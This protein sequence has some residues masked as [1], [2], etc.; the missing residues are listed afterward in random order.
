MLRILSFVDAAGGLEL[1][2]PV[3]PPG[4]DWVRS[5]LYETVHIDQLGTINYP[6]GKKPHSAV[7]ECLLPAHHY[8]FMVPGAVADPRHYLDQFERWRRDATVLRYVVSGTDINEPVRIQEIKQGED[9]GTNDV[10]ATL[11]LLEY[12][13]PEVAVSNSDTFS[14]A[15][16]ESGCAI[17]TAVT[18]VVRA[19]DTLSSIARRYYG[20]ASLYWRLA[21]ANGIKNANLIW[22]G[23]VLTIPVKGDLPAAVPQS[24][25]P[26]SAQVAAGADGSAGR[27]ILDGTWKSRIN[28]VTLR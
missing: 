21:A 20:D 6:A 18:Y 3:T 2:L 11:A 13:A 23:Q 4:Y 22:V 26:Q 10:T 8:S 12:L 25:R 5:T 17:N 28:L 19:G 9:D 1:P 27:I 15:G 14:G 24:K 16:R 7:L